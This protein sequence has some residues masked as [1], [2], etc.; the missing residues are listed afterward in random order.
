MTWITA[1]GIVRRFVLSYILLK[2][3]R[4]KVMWWNNTVLNPRALKLRVKYVVGGEVGMR[5]VAPMI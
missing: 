3:V 1:E 5:N 2:R 4:T